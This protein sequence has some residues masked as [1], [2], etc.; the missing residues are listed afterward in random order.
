[1]HSYECDH[2]LVVFVAVCSG[3]QRHDHLYYSIL[4]TLMTYQNVN[5]FIRIYEYLKNFEL[6][7]FSLTFLQ[8]VVQSFLFNFYTKAIYK[9]TNYGESV[10]SNPQILVKH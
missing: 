8:V 10:A 7:F 3:L 4:E 6:C 9:F 1:M 5:F 2:Q